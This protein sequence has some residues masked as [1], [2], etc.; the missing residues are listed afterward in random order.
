MR[1]EGSIGEWG[2]STRVFLALLPELRTRHCVL[3]R[4]RLTQV[5][6]TWHLH[7]DRACA[8]GSFQRVSGT[9]PYSLSMS[10]APD[11]RARAGAIAWLDGVLEEGTQ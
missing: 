5:L 7:D 2:L 8:S 9:V 4:I 3:L 6:F 11:G 1:Q 10:M